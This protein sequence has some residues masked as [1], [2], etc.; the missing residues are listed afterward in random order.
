MNGSL[1][2]LIPLSMRKNHA[3]RWAMASA[4]L[5]LLAVGAG[6][7][8]DQ[9]AFDNPPSGT[10]APTYGTTGNVPQGM[11]ADMPADMNGNVPQGN[12][13]GINGNV[14]QGNA[15]G[16]TGNVPQGNATT[17]ASAM[18]QIEFAKAMVRLWEDHITWTR[19]YIISAAEGLQDK[20]QTAARL[21]KNQED[22][23]NAMKP[24]YGDAAGDQLTALLKEHIGGAVKVIDAA[25]A[26]DQAKLDAEKKSWYENGDE[27]AEFLSKA[28]PQHW[29]LEA[30]K[31]EMKMHLDVTF[32]E[33]SDRLAKK[34]DDDIKDYDEVKTHIY[35]LAATLVE[36]IIK[37]FPDKF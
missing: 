8:R 26:G 20:T 3:T 32:K 15:Y 27:I 37:Q 36:G 25:K 12:A 22:I 7:P 21:M 1:I 23:G 34:Y 11:N 30:L 14:P 17:P 31:A 19:L 2:P 16:T 5:G 28:N 29:P 4:V 35:G 10:D 9:Y 33:A 6:C 13:Y 24:Y 18:K